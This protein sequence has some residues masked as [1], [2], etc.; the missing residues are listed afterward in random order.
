MLTVEFLCLQLCLG[1]FLLTSEALLLM[2]EVLLL[3]V[4]VS[5]LAVGNGVCRTVVIVMLPLRCRSQGCK[6]ELEKKKPTK[7]EERSWGIVPGVD[8]RQNCLFYVSVLVMFY[9][10]RKRKQSPQKI[11]GHSPACIVCVCV[12]VSVCLCFGLQCYSDTPYSR[13]KENNFQQR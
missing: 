1:A 9:G 7:D 8:W 12:C 11:L 2:L 6:P 10:K 3:T 4:E 5:L 13:L